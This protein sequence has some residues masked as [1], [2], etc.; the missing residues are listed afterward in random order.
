VQLDSRPSVTVA[1]IVKDNEIYLP[2]TLTPAE[3]RW[4]IAIQSN[5]EV[6]V[7]AH[8]LV[9]D[10]HA[11]QVADEALH[12]E[13]SRLGAEKYSQSYFIPEN[14]WFFHLVER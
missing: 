9:Y 10:F 6:R 1:V 3:K 13:L 11:Y 2:A 14:T 5:P 12:N 8:D 4:P 7:R